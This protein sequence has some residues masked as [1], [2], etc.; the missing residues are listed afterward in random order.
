MV[1]RSVGYLARPEGG[2]PRPVQGFEG[3]CQNRPWQPDEGT[4]ATCGGKAQGPEPSR[5]PRGRI[6][7]Q[8]DV[9]RGFAE[10]LGIL[11]ATLPE[12]AG[13]IGIG[14]GAVEAMVIAEAL[15]TPGKR[16]HRQMGGLA[17]PREVTYPG[18]CSTIRPSHRS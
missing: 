16:D 11:G 8:P 10:E 18:H 9:W 13:G 5:G 2:S 3:V 15:G 4:I 1:G 7:W 6:C 14:G 17:A 12:D